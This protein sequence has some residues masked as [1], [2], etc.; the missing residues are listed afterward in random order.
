MKTFLLAFSFSFLLMS[1]PFL[2]KAISMGDLV[3]KI[4]DQETG[5]GV[6]CA[7]L[8]LENGFDKIT[9]TANE[10]GN[11]YAL[12]VPEG[13]Y[14]LRVAYNQRLFVMNKVKV[15]DGYANQVDI[16]VSGDNDLPA[17]VILPYVEPFI[18]PLQ[19]HDIIV[20]NNG[21]DRAP[22]QL[23]DLLMSLTG[24]RRIGRYRFS[25]LKAQ[26]AREFNSILT[27]RL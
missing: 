6:P 13:R 24:Y 14:Q 7:E 25:G 21:A 23:S 22:Q 11:Y 12:H 15:Y 27:V 16:K 3:G 9:V 19:P 2:S 20:T 1:S 5:Q 8:V 17:T 10:F 26:A 18:N 4:T